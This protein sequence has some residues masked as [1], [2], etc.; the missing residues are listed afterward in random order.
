MMCYLQ[1]CFSSISYLPV[2]ITKRFCSGKNRTVVSYLEYPGSNLR[3][4]IW[5][6]FSPGL[7][8]E[9]SKSKSIRFN[10]HCLIKVL[11][12]ITCIVRCYMYS[13]YCYN[14][15]VLLIFYTMIN[16]ICKCFDMSVIL[17]GNT[18]GCLCFMGYKLC[19]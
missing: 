14:V 6:C 9:I 17:H 2:K 7:F 3:G 18:V 8:D 16:I 19:E 15:A 13:C 1:V 4:V 5:F 12:A 10:I 11:Y